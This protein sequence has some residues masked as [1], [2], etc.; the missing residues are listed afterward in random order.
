M[1]SA[2]SASSGRPSSPATT[3]NPTVVDFSMSG[4]TS[5]TAS[6]TLFA[7]RNG[8]TNG[9]TQNLQLLLPDGANPSSE[10]VTVNSITPVASG[11]DTAAILV[12]LTVNSTTLATYASS[13]TDNL[14]NNYTNGILLQFVATPPANGYTLTPYTEMVYLRPD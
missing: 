9:S 2:A 1:N 13:A 6:I 12:N 11:T 8:I 4:L 14:G 3:D 7:A 5:Q 10:G